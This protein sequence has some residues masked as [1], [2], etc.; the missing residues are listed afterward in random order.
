MAPPP[1][2]PPAPP[3]AAT[4][5]AA[6]PE[7]R[8][9]LRLRLRQGRVDDVEIRST[10]PR[11]LARA[12]L[13]HAPGEAAA[14][15]RRLF[16]LC[17]QAQGA[18][19]LAACAAARGDPGAGA[20]I[21]ALLRE[22]ALEHAWRLLLDWP[23]DL[24]LAPD[25]ASLLRLRQAPAEG[26]AQALETCQED[27][28]LGE[29]PSAWL[30]RGLDGLDAWSAQGATPLARLF[31]RLHAPLPDQ[32]DPGIGHAPLL[33]AL[34]E[35]S[36][37]MA[38]KL[39]RRALE[40]AHFTARPDWNGQPAETGALARTAHHPMLAQWL[41][42]RGR[43]QGARLL[44]RLLE[45]AELPRHAAN[46]GPS[47]IRAWQL[48]TGVGLAGVETSRGL[49]FHLARLEDGAIADYR[50][51]APTEWNFHPAGPLRQALAGLPEEAGLPA[52]ARSLA[53]ALDPC[54]A[55]DVEVA[56]A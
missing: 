30:R 32:P 1:P 38:A 44:A 22:R 16:S 52:R 45:L 51:L 27:A 48:E 23:R 21:P 18:A 53:R 46:G 3:L 28:L 43:G 14:L 47:P 40:E 37:A 15:A 35:W 39:G 5:P 19:V 4:G 24:E 7:G 33:P 13:G 20:D 36:P 54:V 29:A 41:A 55:F 25:M 50:I 2:S 9:L 56:H 26:F 31:A 11:G 49:L 17:G 34:A 42:R 10:R 6:D 12:M 8:I